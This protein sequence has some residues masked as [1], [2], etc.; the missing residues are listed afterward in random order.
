M[1]IT[2]IWQKQPQKKSLINHML[3]TGIVAECLTDTN[4]I[5]HPVL[6]RLSE[7]TGCD[8]DT[9]LTKIVFICAIHDIGKIHPTFQG[10]DEETLE[11]LRQE[12]LNQVSFDT[13]FRHEQYGANIFDRLSVDDA[14]MKNSDIISQ[15]IRMH[16]QKEQKKNSDIDII[17]IDDKEKAKKWRHIQNEIYDYVKNIFDLTI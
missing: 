9:L 6:N 15:I 12:N 11:M 10:R 2:K 5:Y 16:H 8:S 3:E 17:K 4:G 1:D 14:D 7:I 13:R